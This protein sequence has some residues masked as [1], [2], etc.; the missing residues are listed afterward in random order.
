MIRSA[1]LSLLTAATVA[2]G[3]SAQVNVPPRPSRGAAHEPPPPIV[4]LPDSTGFGVPVLAVAK[5]PD[6]ALWVGTYGRGI[7]VLKPGDST[8]THIV[9]DRNNDKS[10]S[11]DFIHAFAFP[12]PGVV[13]Y[14]AVGNGW[15]VSLD[16]GQTLKNWTGDELGPEYQYTI[17]DGIVVRGDTVYIGTADGVM[18]TWDDGHNWEVLVDSAGPQT[19][20]LGAKEYPVLRNEYVKQIMADRQGIAVATLRGNQRLQRGPA[21]WSAQP[22]AIV[23]FRPRKSVQLGR[24][25]LKGTNCG[26]V[27]RGTASDTTCYATVRAVPT[28]SGRPPRT[29]WFQ[30]PIWGGDQPLIDQT[31]RYGSTFGGTF[32]PHQGV[33]FNNPDGTPVHAIGSGVVV[34]AG[35]A[36]QGALTVAIRMDSTLTGI[37]PR[38]PVDTTPVER[39]KL[40]LFS[41]YYHN[42]ELKVKVGDRVRAGQVISLVGNTGRATND[43]LHVEV[44]ASP[45]DSVKYIVDPN[46]R[47]PHY[48]TNT[49]LW[50]QPAGARAGWVAGQVFDAAGHAVPQAHIFGLSKFEPAE[51]PLVMMETYGPKNHMHPLYQEHFAIGDVPVGE[52]TLGVEIDGKKVWR[53]VTVTEGNL[54][55]VV[56]RP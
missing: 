20:R 54:T 19:N 48:T 13:W 3:L 36:E 28:D 18:L 22:A 33:E 2:A 8:W 39:A 32:Q 56:F 35:P 4:P 29:A 50:L 37:V 21:G 11:F 46:E 7:Y 51:T 16:G 49:E 55:W 52:Y 15:G 30:R 14:G 12:R 40:Y 41:V 10:I 9:R 26:L 23:A 53:K 17:P 24:W 45:V 42:S 25:L 44:H 1:L 27:F 31:Y 47:Y 38:S 43:H 6:G 5:A 34:W